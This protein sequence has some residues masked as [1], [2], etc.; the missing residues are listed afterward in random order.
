M[1]KIHATNTWTISNNTLLSIPWPAQVHYTPKTRFQIRR[2]RQSRNIKL[3]IKSRDAKLVY[4]R[5][6]GKLANNQLYIFKNCHFAF[7]QVVS[8][9]YVI[10]SWID[11]FDW[12][13]LRKHFFLFNSGN[14]QSKHRIHLWHVSVILQWRE[15]MISKITYTTKRTQ[16]E[17]PGVMLPKVQYRQV[18]FM[19]AHAS[20]T[21]N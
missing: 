21:G 15:S 3:S 9:L 11:Q 19:Q 6:Q 10:L 12:K 4:N 8:G 2:G 14:V 20:L 13:Q 1:R 18:S 7:S 17:F 16:N 5:Q